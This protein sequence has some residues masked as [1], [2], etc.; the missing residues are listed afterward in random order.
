[1]AITSLDDYISSTKNLIQYAKVVSNTAVTANRSSIYAVAGNPGAGVLTRSNTTSG[2]II[3]NSVAG[4]PSFYVS[5]TNVYLTRV[6]LTSSVAS[7][8]V[9]QDLLYVAGTY[10]FNSNVTLSSQPSI[11]SR[12]VSAN[13]S[14]V[15]MYFE[16]VTAFTGSPTITVTYTNQS[17]TTGRTASIS[18]A[19]MTTPGRLVRLSLQTGDTGVQK[20][21]SVVATV[22][23][24]GTFN[25]H[26]VRDLY[27]GRV[28]TNNSVTQGS[29]ESVG[30]PEIFPT[31]ALN[32]VVIP[33]STSTGLVQG[34][35]EVASK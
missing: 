25:I 15:S 18:G 1:M 24:A 22:A 31:S 32:V 11:E 12:L 4:F 14:E 7:L 23:T 28:S 13:Y 26:L 27:V 19:S 3:T 8:I 2:D 33:D 17:G 16:C 29:I 9:V 6:A 5:G 35:L 34:I 30:M 10:S 21:D 20:I